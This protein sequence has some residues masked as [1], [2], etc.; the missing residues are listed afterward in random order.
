V[1]QFVISMQNHGFPLTIGQLKEK[2]ATIT[3]TRVTPF[4]DGIPGEGW[5]RCFKR[6]HPELVLRKSQTLEGNRASGLNP[7]SVSSFYN[8]LQKLYTHRGYAPHQI[9]NC[10]ESGAQAGRG[11]GG[12]VIAKRGSKIVHNIIPNQR[13]WLTVLVCINANGESIPSY[14]IFK[15]KR[16]SSD[17]LRKTGEKGATLSM[18]PKAWMTHMLFL[19]WI[20]YFIKNVS[21]RYPISPSDRHC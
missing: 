6:R 3:Q 4:K 18:Q 9:W 12:Y 17:F 15:G 14:Y 13:E 2:V 8:N 11:G 1:V 21:L 7:E 20:H 19:R 16:R 10:D 5:V